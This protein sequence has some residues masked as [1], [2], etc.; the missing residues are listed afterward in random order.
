MQKQ[1]HSLESQ[2]NK[3]IQNQKIYE[4]DKKSMN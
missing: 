3:L 1:I 4:D 2:R